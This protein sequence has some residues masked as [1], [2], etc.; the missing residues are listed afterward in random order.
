[1]CASPLGIECLNWTNE[2]LGL[3]CLLTN[4]HPMAQKRDDLRVVEIDVFNK[5][6]THSLHNY[7][8]H[9]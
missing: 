7:R 9:V 3:D 6:C 2:E 5:E 1:M 4:S 8:F